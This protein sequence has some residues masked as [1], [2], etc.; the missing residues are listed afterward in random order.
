MNST[1][2]RCLLLAALALWLPVSAIGQLGSWS[3]YSRS[4]HAVTVHAGEAA[5]RFVFYHPNV[6]RIDFLPSPSTWFDSSFVVVR[7]TSDPVPVSV[8]ETDST[9]T[10][11]GGAI[12]AVCTK[13]PVRVRYYDGSGR[14]LIEEDTAGGSA[15]NGAQ[16][17]MSF[18]MQPAEHYYGMGGQG[19]P[20]D[21]R[22]QAFQM[23]NTAWY[24]YGG[25][26]PTANLTVPLVLSTGGYALYF[27]NTYPGYAD[28]GVARE[29]VFTYRTS[30][31]ELSCFLLAAPDPA[32]QLELY[33][34]L[35]GRQPMPPRWA[36]GYL[37][38]KYGYRTELEARTAAAE[39]R[40][41]H[42]PCDV[43]VLDLFWYRNMGDLAW[44]RSAWPNPAGMIADFRA[45][46]INTVVIT[47]PYVT[48]P[49]ATFAEGSGLGYLARNLSGQTYVLENWWSC[50]C[51]AGL[52]D[53]TSPAVRQWFWQKHLSFLGDGV[54]GLW[55]DLGEPERHPLDM[56]HQLGPAQ[57]VH[58]IYNLLWAQMVAEGFA[59]LRP[60][61]RIFNL[62]RSGYA[63]I[64]RYGVFTWSGDVAKTYGGLAVQVPMMLSMG[65]SGL[66]YHHS[67]IGGF[68]CGWTTPELYLRW[69]QLGVFAPV[70][71]AHGAGE[72]VGG[73]A[74][75]PWAFGPEAES[76]ARDLIRLRYQMLPYNY[77]M[78]WKNHQN[79]TPL[80]RP[81]V[82]ENPRREE[83]AGEAAAYL[84]GD[85]FLVAPVVTEG[86]TTAQVPLPAGTWIN[87]WTDEIV[88]GGGT[89]SVSAPLA[90]V[91]LFVRAGS[92]VPLQPV[93]E[94]SNQ[95]PPDTLIVRIYPGR[96]SP[97]TFT[98]Y[99]DD[100]E[101]T[102]YLSGLY[103]TTTFSQSTQIAGGD[104]T[105]AVMIGASH[106]GYSGK[107]RHRSYVVEIRGVTGAPGEVA[108][109]G[110]P[111]VLTPGYDSL[112]VTA[113]SYFYD[114][115]GR[116]LSAHLL[117]DADSAYELSVGGIQLSTVPGAE[118][119]P[120]RL[121]LVQNYPNP[122]NP[123]T[124]IRFSIPGRGPVTVRIYD[125]LGRMVET[126]VDEVREAGTY[127]V[128][129]H[130]AKSPSGVYLCRLSASGSSIARRLLLIR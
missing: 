57:K 63:G 64:Q 47:Q 108:K 105:L 124:T 20:L 83:F 26:L 45:T 35:T 90:Q 54:A 32:S 86:Q 107:P 80:A 99:E 31:G 30:G 52:V 60:Q 106:G 49:T 21:R 68:C 53:L 88:E 73:Q 29:G 25:P 91:P 126:L 50:G 34:W 94:Y 66:A 33:T 11:T 122:F 38:S 65:L 4:D 37:Q 6:L 89:V 71:R 102:G 48:S 82:F 72:A 103:S 51:S 46:G 84:W 113:D 41:R 101:S 12:R 78:A 96:G 119:L 74:T 115:S 27:E 17:L 10:V 61:A 92:I 56:V 28:F 36:L 43:I 5:L 59:S 87:V 44:D 1:V 117:T 55:T 22:G 127:E 58:N 100:G 2:F 79:G 109:N 85:A 39:M 110:S 69:L 97:G 23:S 24:G 111:L 130:P 95:H 75:E 70:T 8:E 93:S 9:F 42:F 14:L 67:D 129:W 98:L 125:L 3:G 62:T 15:A 123:S 121:L 118:V 120:Q 40:A 81:L 128:T 112:R 76:V 77:T 16:R 116:I 114:A 19:T 104:S 18:R 7:D 13:V